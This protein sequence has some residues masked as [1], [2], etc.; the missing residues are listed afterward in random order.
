MLTKNFKSFLLIVTNLLL[1]TYCVNCGQTP[2]E[3][4]KYYGE[5]IVYEEQTPFQKLVYTTNK[6]ILRMYLDDNIQFSSVDEHRYHEALVHPV[7]IAAPN[8]E[9]VLII[10]G[11]DGLALREVFKYKEV[12]KVTLVDIDKVVTRIAST[13][14]PLV[15]LNQRSMHSDKVTIKNM[16]GYAFIRDGKELFDVMIIDLPDPYSKQV[17]RLYSKEFYIMVK[18]R[19]S[20]NGFFVT[21]SSGVVSAREVFWCINN[22]IAAAGMKVLPY[23]VDV[24]AF[25]DWGFNLAGRK[26]PVVE[27]KDLSVPVKFLNEK[28]FKEMKIFGKKS[29]R[30]KVGINTLDDML[31]LRLYKGIPAGDEDE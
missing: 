15:K 19:L 26:K 10:G 12:K 8:K 3:V 23:H 11:G 24:P 20:E 14:E 21:Q 6:G 25:E 29:S 1:I 31:N 13:L 27:Y 4:K 28:I 9:R 5:T 18:A 17:N 7:M 30:V 16:D 2:K 22:T